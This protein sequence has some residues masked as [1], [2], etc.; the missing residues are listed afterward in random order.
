MIPATTPTMRDYYRHVHDLEAELFFLGCFAAEQKNPFPELQEGDFYG[1]SYRKLFKAFVA[2]D[3]TPDVS[4]AARYGVEQGVWLSVL[5]AVGSAAQGEYLG[6]KIRH[7]SMRRAAIAD[8][9][10]KLDLLADPCTDRDQVDAILGATA[11]G[12]RELVKT[13]DQVWEEAQAQYKGM[14][15]GFTCDIAH[16]R[17]ILALSAPGD[18]IVIA[19]ASGVGKTSLG[20]QICEHYRTLFISGEMPAI[21]LLR[22][23]H[24]MEYW[25]VAETEDEG[26]FASENDQNKQFHGA[27]GSGE[28]RAMLHDSWRYITDPVSIDELDA[29]IAYTGELDMVLVDYLQL[30]KGAKD[31]DRRNQMA[32][33]ARGMKQL[34]KKHNVRI[35]SLCQIS[36]PALGNPA[37]DPATVVVT[38]GRLKESG[39]IE[40][41]ADYVLGMWL[42]LSRETYIQAIQDI[43]NRN[44]G[45]HPV[46]YLK[47]SGPWFRD[48]DDAEVEASAYLDAP[49]QT[50]VNKGVKWTPE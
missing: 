26:I 36:R 4:N 19:C 48:A 13:A 23:T 35:V 33:L 38:L 44:A 15:R 2:G 12:V 3:Y 21:N 29:A 5:E 30:M 9:M 37:T 7:L 34:A 24:A 14:R 42:H 46:A 31:A 6:R 22:R 10:R 1:E 40:E 17:H 47:R 11:T 43:K 50:R 39:D 25:K 18:H 45:V 8:A 28:G 41:S 27:M 32:G 20:I 49:Q 16:L